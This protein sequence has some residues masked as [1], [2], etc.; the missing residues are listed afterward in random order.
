M[1]FTS[2]LRSNGTATVT[3]LPAPSDPTD[4]ATKGYVDSTIEGLSFKAKCRVAT[5]SNI[6]LASPGA[7]INGIT[8][9]L[10]DRV[11]VLLQTLTK[12]NG[13]YIFNGAST[14]M[15]RAA[16]ASTAEE[17]T[18]AVVTVEE[19]DSEG[20]TYR[21]SAINFV[22]G[23]DPIVWEAFN[24]GAGPASETVSGIV[25]IATQEETDEGTDDQR[26]VTPLKLAAWSRAKLKYT[27]LFGDGS[28]TQ[29]DLTHN[30]GTKHVQVTVYEASTDEEVL[31][32]KKSLSNSAFR[33]TFSS[34]PASDSYYAVIL[35]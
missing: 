5:V 35:G 31:C 25:E 30:L 23:T 29:F 20:A 28:S 1:K 13:I 34:A 26:A 8:L 2:N 27:A 7:A 21:Q 6:D 11:L 19:G 22:L 4:V 33:L 16:D 24:T 9:S 10:N 3:N 17:L 15:T 32:D 14:P 12:D 18:Q